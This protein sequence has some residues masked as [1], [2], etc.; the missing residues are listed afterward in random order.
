MTT[1]KLKFNVDTINNSLRNYSLYLIKEELLSEAIKKDEINAAEIS[2]INI[3]NET[4]LERAERL[5]NIA[6]RH[7]LNINSLTLLQKNIELTASEI[8]KYIV[9]HN[10]KSIFYTLKRNGFKNRR[11]QF[12]ITTNGRLSVLLV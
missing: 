4:D 12:Q 3:E 1:T 8:V 6:K 10:K 9:N 2:T 5:L 7:R 11:Y